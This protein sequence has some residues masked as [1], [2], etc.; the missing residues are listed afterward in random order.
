MVTSLPSRVPPWN[1]GEAPVSF[2]LYGASPLFSASFAAVAYKPSTMEFLFIVDLLSFL[3][4]TTRNRSPVGC[5]SLTPPTV[6]QQM[7]LVPQRHDAPGRRLRASSN[8]TRATVITISFGQSLEKGVDFQVHAPCSCHV[9]LIAWWPASS[10]LCSIIGVAG[11]TLERFLARIHDEVA[12]AVLLGDLDCGERNS[13]VLFADAQKAS[14]AENDGGDLPVFVEQHIVYVAD[15]VILS[16][17][18]RLLVVLA[19][20]DAAVRHRGQK[21]FLFRGRRQ[22]CRG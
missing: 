22:S 12:I 20:R 2:P 1:R 14:D 19:D 3:K 5:R 16:V 9:S 7:R 18:D 11:C 13:H 6:S 21:H 17:V 10:A 4:E 8:A 15:L